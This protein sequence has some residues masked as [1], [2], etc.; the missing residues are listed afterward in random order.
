[1]FDAERLLGGLVFGGLRR[2]SGL[3]S[4]MQGAAGMA[5]LGVAIAAFEHFMKSSPTPSVSSPPP[6][7]TYS[8]PPPLPG[9]APIPDAKPVI[10]PPLRTS[11]DQQAILLI[12]AMISAANADSTISQEERNRILDRMR[13]VEMTPEEQSFMENE[14][15]APATLDEIAGE[16][17]TPDEARQVYAASLMAIEVDTD[18]E[19]K[20]LKTLAQRLGLDDVTISGI[21]QVLGIQPQF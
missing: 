8:S 5:V 16:I 2:K 3:G 6:E 18:A 4:A 12:R 11:R 9:R 15:L 13:R 10:P 7:T 21:H 14:L 20:Y 17:K 19:R 1:M